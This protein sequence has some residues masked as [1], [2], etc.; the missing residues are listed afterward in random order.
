MDEYE[1]K[2][3][4]QQLRIWQITAWAEFVIGLLWFVKAMSAV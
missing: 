3:L 4:K 1:I 2:R